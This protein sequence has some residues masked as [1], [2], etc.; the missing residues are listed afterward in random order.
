LKHDKC[1]INYG[2]DSWKYKTLAPSNKKE[3]VLKYS[4]KYPTFVNRH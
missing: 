3:M 4:V 2:I 1:T